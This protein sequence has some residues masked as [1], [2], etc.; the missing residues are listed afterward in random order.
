MRKEEV[1][2]GYLVYVGYTVLGVYGLKRR[3]GIISKHRYATVFMFTFS[4]VLYFIF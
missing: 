4:F 1:D 2:Y 3:Q